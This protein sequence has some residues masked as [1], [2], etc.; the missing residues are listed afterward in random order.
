[1]CDGCFSYTRKQM[2]SYNNNSND[3]DKKMNCGQ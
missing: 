1:M 2:R 3:N